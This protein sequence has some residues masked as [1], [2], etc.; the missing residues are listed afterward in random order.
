VGKV[1]KL[2]SVNLGVLVECL[3]TLKPFIVQDSARPK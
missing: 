3:C 2:E 1:G